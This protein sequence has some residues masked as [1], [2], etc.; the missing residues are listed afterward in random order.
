[1]RR[2]DIPSEPGT[3]A[4]V[5][6]CKKIGTVRIGRLGDLALQPGVYI[7]VGSACAIH[8][9][10]DARVALPQSPI[11]HDAPRSYSTKS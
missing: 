10:R 11:L 1:M 6:A 5:L 4:L 3:Y 8:G 7:Y 9:R 2:L